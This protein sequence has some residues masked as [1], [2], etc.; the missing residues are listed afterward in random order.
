MNTFGAQQMVLMK[1]YL[2]SSDSVDGVGQTRDG[3]EPKRYRT[4]SPQLMLGES[5]C[6]S[7]VRT[8]IICLIFS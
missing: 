2:S 4:R 5:W 6:T 1:R 3:R 8:K 7:A